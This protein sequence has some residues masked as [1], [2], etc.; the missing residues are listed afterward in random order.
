MDEEEIITSRLQSREQH[1]KAC[2]KGL[3]AL[4]TTLDAGK[5]GEADKALESLCKQL[6]QYEFAVAK[7]AVTMTSQRAQVADYDA[8]C[9][10][11]DE[12]MQTVEA[13]IEKLK[14]KLVAAREER[15]HREQCASLERLINELPSRD[16]MTQEITALERE[17]QTLDH[18]ADKIT[19]EL[20]QRQLQFATLLHCAHN[21]QT[22]L[23]DAPEGD[24]APMQD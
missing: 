18:E 10:Q 9:L 7:A 19:A 14:K 24:G 8:T 11:I 12:D 16:E 3:A 17:L 23:R 6:A 15:D 21:L 2:A 1:L 13:D 22:Q 20:Q 5:E 4:V